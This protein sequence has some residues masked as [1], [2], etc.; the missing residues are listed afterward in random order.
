VV[1][2]DLLTVDVFRLYDVD[3]AVTRSLATEVGP[4]IDA[5]I[6]V[7]DAPAEATECDAIITVTDSKTPVLDDGWLDGSEFVV[8]LGSYRELPDATILGADHIVVDHVEQCR[9]RGAL[10][11]LVDRNE[12]SRSDFDGTIG[13]VLANDRQGMVGRDERGIFVPIGLGGL[14]IAVAE[15]VHRAEGGPVQEFDF[16]GG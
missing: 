10:A 12:L 8:A 6:E 15:C 13:E 2:D 14:D 16:V 11:D 7:C 1:I 4:R 3:R 5:G 9:Q